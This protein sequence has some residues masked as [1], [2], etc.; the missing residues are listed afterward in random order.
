MVL[1]FWCPARGQSAQSGNRTLVAEGDTVQ[2]SKDGDKP[3]QHWKLWRLSDGGY[4]VVD[5][6]LENAS[7]VQTFHFDSKLQPVAFSVKFGPAPATSPEKGKSVSISCQYK[8]KKLSCDTESAEGEKSAASVATDPP[9]VFI[10]EFYQLDIAWFMTG[11]VNF[12]A[13][14]QTKRGLVNVYFLTQRDKH[15]DLRL[16]RDKPIK[17]ALLGE[18]TAT[19]AGKEQVL[20]KYQW[21]AVNDLYILRVNARG[22]VVEITDKTNP[23]Y[24]FAIRNYKEYG[25]WGTNP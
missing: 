1:A 19:W 3:L 4:E 22:M 15:N 24:G 14:D 18:D 6:S 5:T 25:S 2:I 21:E 13:Q 12:A 11:A 10:F 7:L 16:E 9:Y 8:P 20:K 23:S 17:I